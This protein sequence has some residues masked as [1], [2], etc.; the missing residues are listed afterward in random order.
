MSRRARLAERQN[1][2]ADCARVT[3]PT[4]VVTGERDLDQ[5]VPCD[6]THELSRPHSRLELSAVRAHRPS[7]HGAGARS[8]CRN[9]LA[10]LPNLMTDDIRVINV[11]IPGP[12]GLLEGLINAQDRR[13]AAR[14]R[15]ARTSACRPP[16]ERCTR[17]PCFTRR[18]RSRAST[19]LCCGSTFAASAEA[20]A[21]FR[22]VPA[23]RRTFA[24]RS[25]S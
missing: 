19:C 23:S 2:E 3:V 7:R 10:I 16:A 4:L 18:R 21:R 24:L 17:R 20:P 11:D 5:V 6:E 12:A 14:H 8:L 22:T 15:R 1:F 25:L 13:R 9:R